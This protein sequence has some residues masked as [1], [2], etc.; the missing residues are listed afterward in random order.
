ML[1]NSDSSE[2]L[3]AFD[4]RS[5]GSGRVGGGG[6]AKRKTNPWRGGRESR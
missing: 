5:E 3:L 1:R 6:D 2:T 4:I